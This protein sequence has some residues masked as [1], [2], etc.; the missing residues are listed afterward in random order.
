MPALPLS[1]EQHA[2]ARRLKAIFEQWKAARK[3]DGLPSGQLALGVLLDIN[4]SAVSQYLNGGIP[5]NAPAAAKFAKIF[6]CQIDDFSLTL[7]SE[8]KVIGEA[9]ATAGGDDSAGPADLTSLSKLEMQLVLMYRDLPNESKD[10]LL[11]LANRLHGV[12]RPQKS[13]ANPFPHA[14]IPSASPAPPPA[15]SAARKRAPRKTKEPQSQ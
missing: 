3:K 1:P 14:P 11:Q 6:G 8:A 2:D 13:A 15:K 5:L 9:V 10:D 4:Q 7:A 12:A